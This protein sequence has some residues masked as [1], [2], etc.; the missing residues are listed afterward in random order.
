MTDSFTSAA[1]SASPSA[2]PDV[3]LASAVDFV[4]RLYN[5][6]TIRYQKLLDDSVWFRQ[7]RWLFTGFIL[8]LY[9]GKVWLIHDGGWYIVTYGLAIYILNSL[10][11][12][13]SPLVDPAFEEMLMEDAEEDGAGDATVLPT[14][15]RSQGAA[16]GEWK[17]FLRRVPEFKFWCTFPASVFRR[18]VRLFLRAFFRDT[19][20]CEPRKRV[21]WRFCA[22]SSPAWTC[23]S[24]GRSSCF[25][26]SSC[27]W[28]P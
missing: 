12:F 10:L 14:V 9:V 18:V 5:S 28:R 17:P 26:S 13:L 19:A 23:P 11:G 1:R 16:D 27:S 8:L 15:N 6:L 25:T 7:R 4:A 21:L 2:T 22:L 24:T 3:S 20:G